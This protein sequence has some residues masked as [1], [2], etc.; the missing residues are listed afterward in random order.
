MK[1]LSEGIT[2]IIILT[3]AVIMTLVVIGFVF[4]LFGAL[5]PMIEAY[6]VYNA[7]IYSQNGKYY[8]NFSIKNNL[9]ITIDSVQVVGTPLVNSTQIYL[10]P[11]VH[12]LKTEF[13][14]SA[15]LAQGN[16]YTIEIALSNGNSISVSASY[17]G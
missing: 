14:Q 11:G 5:S 15:N 3:A 6:Q 7:V 8:V 13:T 12:T 2:Q 1:G 10:P 16:V 4:G 9:A 17:E